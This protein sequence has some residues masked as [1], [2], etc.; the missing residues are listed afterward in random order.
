M[1]LTRLVVMGVMGLSMGLFAARGAQADDRGHHGGRPAYHGDHGHSYGHSHG[2]TR[3]YRPYRSYSYGYA[4]PYYY[5]GYR[6]YSYYAPGYYAPYDPYAYV[7]PPVYVP[8]RP[9]YRPG[10]SLS[11]GFGF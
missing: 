2:Y 6:G 9:Y 5:G 1:K 3:S 10:V 7:P 8:Y 4:R 11:L